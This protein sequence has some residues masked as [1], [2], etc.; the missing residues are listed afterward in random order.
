MYRRLATSLVAA[1]LA[2][3]AL[4]P[5]ASAQ[6]GPAPVWPCVDG[7]QFAAEPGQP[8]RFGC[9][10]SAITLGQIRDYLTAHR[11]TL[12]V[13]DAQDEVVLSIGPR[14]FATL[15]LPIERY[16]I[17]DPELRCASPTSTVVWWFYTLE[18]G[19][20]AGTYTVTLGETLRHPVMDGFHTCWLADG[21]RAVPAPSLYPAASWESV[22]TLIVAD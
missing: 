12:T 5:G 16:P 8:I 19:L 18:A 17:D 3:S 13:R 21:E 11:A 9:G 6:T 22:S 14:Q 1:A 20:P 2:L 4:A 7:L 10:W 15:W